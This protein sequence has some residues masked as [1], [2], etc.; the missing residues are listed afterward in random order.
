MQV[1]GNAKLRSEN[2]N[3]VSDKLKKELI[4]V[5]KPG[6]IIYFQLL[7]GTFDAQEKREVFGASRSIPLKD[8]IFDPYAVEVKDEKGNLTYE[9]QY[10]DIGVPED[11]EVKNGRVERC[12]K[13]WVES[14][15]NGKPGNGEFQFIG[16]QIKDMEVYEFLCLSNRSNDNPHRDKSKEP[17][18]KRVNPEDDRKKEDEKVYKEALA[19][20]KRFSKDPEKKKEIDAALNPA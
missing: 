6:E 3:G 15:I 16:G 17:S 10:V 18:Y 7:N 1:I 5:V 4:K 9:G 14:L 13:Y 19:K 8:R 2:F 12:K 11:G 20:I